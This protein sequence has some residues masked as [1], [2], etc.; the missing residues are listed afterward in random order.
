MTVKSFDRAISKLKEKNLRRH[1]DSAL[2]FLRQYVL[3]NLR[4]SM[5]NVMSSGG[6]VSRFTVGGMYTY[7]YDPMTKE[8]MPYWDTNPLILFLKPNGHRNFYGINVHYLT[9]RQRQVIFEHL[10]NTLN[11]TRL[12]ETTKMRINYKELLIASNSVKDAVKQYSYSQLRSPII[13]VDPE[14]WDIM[15]FLPYANFV[16]NENYGKSKD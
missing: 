2:T 1:S 6:K 5:K 7:I 13:K 11:N 8:K 3:K 14:Y 4:G 12:D 16:K 9:P 15:L 10:G